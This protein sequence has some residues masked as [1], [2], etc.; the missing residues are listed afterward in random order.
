VEKSSDKTEANAALLEAAKTA[1]IAAMQVAL[2]AGADPNHRIRPEGQNSTPLHDVADRGRREVVRALV[3]AGADLGALDYFRQVPLD[4]AI[5]HMGGPGKEDFCIWFAELTGAKAAASERALGAAA[6]RGMARL[7]DA[8]VAQGCSVERHAANKRP[9]LAEAA[10][11]GQLECVKRLVELGARVEA[12]GGASCTPL[13]LAARSHDT[14]VVRYLLSVGANPNAQCAEGETPLLKACV[15]D[16]G[17]AEEIAVALLEAGADPAIRNKYDK[18]AWE[19]A[20]GCGAVGVMSAL[21]KANLGQAMGRPQLNEALVFAVKHGHAAMV[22][23]L[24]SRGADPSF[25]SAG[26]TLLQH[27]RKDLP[28]IKELILAARAGVFIDGALGADCGPSEHR[29]DA[30]GEVSGQPA[31]RSPSPM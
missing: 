20:L 30:I 19:W 1:D 10:A 5:Q 29:N 2:A 23:R 6:E 13:H 12:T 14:A 9:P 4:I 17:D 3:A 26:R 15:G 18:A 27:A 28:E 24:L 21:E 31:R 25:R 8:L 16:I 7:I 22:R 11:C